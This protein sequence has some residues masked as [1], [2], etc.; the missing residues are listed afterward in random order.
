MT[1]CSLST[2]TAPPIADVVFF[3]ESIDAKMNRYTLNQLMLRSI[4]TPFLNNSDSKHT[5][6]YVAPSPDTDN[7]PPPPDPAGY[8]YPEGLA[9]LK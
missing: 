5:K 1:D 9:R 7:L 8:T 3:D 2:F 6:T 4:D